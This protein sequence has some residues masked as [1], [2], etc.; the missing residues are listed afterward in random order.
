MP[1]LRVMRD[2]RPYHATA[3]G[4]DRNDIPVFRVGGGNTILCEI[5]YT[6]FLGAETY[7]SGAWTVS[8]AIL[9]TETQ[10]GAL[11]TA[12]V[13]VPDV[14]VSPDEQM[15]GVVTVVHRLTTS[16]GRIHNTPMMLRL[17]P[18]SGTDLFILD[19]SILA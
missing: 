13:S 17:V 9:G 5:D 16:G 2:G 14:V 1:L 6:A 3:G 19:G 12:L 11:V 4:E 15:G 10:S 18:A 7:A 8:G